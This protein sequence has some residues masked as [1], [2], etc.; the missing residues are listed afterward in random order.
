[1]KL[2]MALLFVFACVSMTSP[3]VFCEASEQSED[4]EEPA[5]RGREEI[6]EIL[7][8]SDVVKLLKDQSVKHDQKLNDLHHRVEREIKAVQDHF[9]DVLH[10]IEMSE[11]NFE[12]SINAME[13]TSTDALDRAK[14]VHTESSGSWKMPFL[15][16]IVML[17]GISAWFFK[18]YRKATKHEHLF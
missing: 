4:Q 13:K 10:R 14:K 16:L 17:L 15:F 8:A 9:E 2:M 3:S 1:M 12:R 18:L 5:K 6:E 11:K 7:H